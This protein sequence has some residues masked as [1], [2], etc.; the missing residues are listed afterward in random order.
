AARR[1]AARGGESEGRSRR[2][3]DPRGEPA[4]A[5][6]RDRRRRA[7]AGG[8]HPE[9]AV[10][11]RGGARRDERGRVLVAR[12]TGERFA[13]PRCGASFGWLD[14]TGSRMPKESAPTTRRM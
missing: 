11:R 13:L 6:L 7:R 9:C 1:G 12:R 4:Q 5:A 8:G 10:A 14:V 2:L 3:Q